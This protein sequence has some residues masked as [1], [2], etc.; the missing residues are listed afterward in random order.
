MGRA[1]NEDHD[2][3]VGSQERLDCIVLSRHVVLLLL[4]P[5]CPLQLSIDLRSSLSNS[6]LASV[7]RQLKDPLQGSPADDDVVSFLHLVHGLV[8]RPRPPVSPLALPVPSP[9]YWT[10]PQNP[11]VETPGRCL[12]MAV[13][14]WPANDVC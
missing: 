4:V 7:L 14:G 13:R 2:N 8:P 12:L 6:A 10:L 5:P 11:P 3:E 1:S 9:Y